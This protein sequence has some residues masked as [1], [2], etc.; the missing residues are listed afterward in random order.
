M[1]R[2]ELKEFEHFWQ[3]LLAVLLEAVLRIQIHRRTR[4]LKLKS[5]LDVC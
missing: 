5:K 1:Y 2:V 4:V 3:S